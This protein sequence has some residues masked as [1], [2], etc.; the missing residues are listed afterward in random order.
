V[1]PTLSFVQQLDL[2]ARVRLLGH[3]NKHILPASFPL[4][5]KM[6]KKYLILPIVL[7]AAGAC[8]RLPG[9]ENV[10]ATEEQAWRLDKFVTEWIGRTERSNDDARS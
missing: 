1:P 4:E 6:T 3:R 9:R 5:V 10:F 7:V 8:S 2:R